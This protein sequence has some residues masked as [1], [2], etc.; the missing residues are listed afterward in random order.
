MLFFFTPIIW[1]A[2]QIG[3]GEKIFLI[4]SNFL[5]HFINFFRSGFVNGKI[6]YFSM[7]M[8]T[9]VTILL[10]FVA[11]FLHN[12]YKKKIIFWIDY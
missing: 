9:I 3:H 7:L 11:T 1:Q 2:D 10:F 6:E 8:M 12:K 5:Y 4:E